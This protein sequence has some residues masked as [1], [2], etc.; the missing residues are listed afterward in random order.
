MWKGGKAAW[1]DRG[2]HWAVMQTQQLQP[3]LWGVL[4]PEWLFRA[5]PNWGEH[6]PNWVEMPGLY[7]PPIT[8]HW[9][10]TPLGRGVSLARWFFTGE[11]LPEEAD[12]WRLCAESTPC[13]W[14][15]KGT[16]EQALGAQY[17]F[18]C[19]P[20]FLLSLHHW[21]DWN[22]KSNDGLYMLIVLLLNCWD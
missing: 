3:T 1:V 2:R 18:V 22:L 6:I 21:R 12:S 13:K 14:G 16:K 9:K 5:V 15:N 8:G 7:T 19:F 4:E 17:P 11:A 10:W 20:R